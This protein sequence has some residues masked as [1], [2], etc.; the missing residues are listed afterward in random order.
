MPTDEGPPVIVLVGGVG[1][2]YQGDLDL[3]RVAVGRLAGEDL[4]CHALVEDLHYGA[5][6]VSQRLED[7]RPPHL[8]LVGGVVRGRPPGTVERRRVRPEPMT[9][10]DFQGAIGDAVTGYVSIDLVVDVAAGFGVLPARTVTVEVE[11]AVTGMSEHLS[12]LGEQA[13][14]Q[15]LELVRAEVRLAPLLELADRLSHRW[16]DDPE[17][18]AGAP[19]FSTLGQLLAAIAGLADNGRWGAVFSLR[20]RLRRQIDEG[21]TAEGM[22]TLDWALLWGLLEELDRLLALQA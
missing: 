6:A 2:L 13:L 22:D 10:A 4:G 5:V 7:L 11:P 15:A 8:V 14:E 1:E 19:A 17:R 21:G 12:P 3:G 18:F 20:D 9:P 16:Q